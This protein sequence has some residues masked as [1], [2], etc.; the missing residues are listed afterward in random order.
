M[1]NELPT[2]SSVSRRSRETKAPSVHASR[3]PKQGVIGHKILETLDSL[4]EADVRADGVFVAACGNKERQQK[5]EDRGKGIRRCVRAKWATTVR[6]KEKTDSVVNSDASAKKQQLEPITLDAGTRRHQRRG[7]FCAPT[8]T[9]NTG[10][11][12]LKGGRIETSRKR[13]EGYDASTAMYDEKPTH[14]L[15]GSTAISGSAA[16]YR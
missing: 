7:P 10:V 8:H 4:S 13:L 2:R 1:S 15:P 9:C 3:S 5:H 16:A 12:Y 14:P 6:R 11:L